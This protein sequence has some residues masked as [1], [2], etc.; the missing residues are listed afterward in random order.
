MGTNNALGRLRRRPGDDET[1]ITGTTC[2][3]LALSRIL[4]V[5]VGSGR[6]GWIG[7]EP[8]MNIREDVRR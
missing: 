6:H 4:F 1:D 8:A 5:L 7:T 3:D 2:R